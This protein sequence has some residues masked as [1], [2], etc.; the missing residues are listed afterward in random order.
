MDMA[1]AQPRMTNVTIAV[2]I[3]FYPRMGAPRLYALQGA[4]PGSAALAPTLPQRGEGANAKPKP[5]DG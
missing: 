3:P 4:L 2:F 5:I 1:A